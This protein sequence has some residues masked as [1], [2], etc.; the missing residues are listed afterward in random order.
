MAYLL[1]TCTISE[2]VK[3]KPEPKVVDWF[4]HQ[5]ES[6]LFLSIISWGEIQNGI[7]KLPASKRRVRLEKWLNDELQPLFDR[8]IVNIDEDLITTWAKM[9]A[10]LREKNIVRHAFDSL[11]EATAIHRNLILVTRNEKDFRSSD[12]SIYNPWND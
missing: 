10:R 8:R 11:I 12:V 7:Y 5:E 3:K 9:T 4:E 6:S 2:M 1:D